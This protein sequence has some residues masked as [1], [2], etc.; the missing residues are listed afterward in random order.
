MEGVA[1]SRA[2]ALS[3]LVRFVR[4][5]AKLGGLAGITVWN[6]WVAAGLAVGKALWPGGLFVDFRS[7][8]GLLVGK[9]I[10]F[11]LSTGGGSCSSRII[12]LDGTFPVSGFII[13]GL[14]GFPSALCSG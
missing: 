1:G 6:D 11:D 3:N 13:V 14:A 9:V 10:G 5:C 7:Q 2:A 4:C 8:S 12:I